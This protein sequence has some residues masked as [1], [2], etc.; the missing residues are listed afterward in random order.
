MPEVCGDAAIL[1]PVD[2]VKPLA[3]NLEIA[4]TDSARVQQLRERG[5]QRVQ[6]FR[7]GDTARSMAQTLDEMG[8]RT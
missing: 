6:K 2:E 5:A 7:W 8:D 1:S 3:R 4:L